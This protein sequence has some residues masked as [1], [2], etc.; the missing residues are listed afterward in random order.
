MP[1]R[2]MKP[3]PRTLRSRSGV[4]P[5]RAKVPAEAPSRPV[6]NPLPPLPV[7]IGDVLLD[8]RLEDPA[9]RARAE[10][11]YAR[12]VVERTGGFPV[13]V[14]EEAAEFTAGTAVLYRWQGA[15]VILEPT[16][17]RFVGTRR[18]Q[19]LDSLLRIL[20]SQ[21]L[22]SRS[23]LLLHAATILHEGVAFVLMGRSGAGKSTLARLSPAGS[24]LTDEISLV[25][26]GGG[27]VQ[28]HGTPFWGEFRADG[29][30]RRVR[31]GGLFE[32]V[33]AAGH[34]VEELSRRE[35]LN[36]LLA[37][38][39]FFASGGTARARL[40]ALALRFVERVPIRRLHFLPEPGFRGALT[41]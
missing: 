27:G 11:R 26:L 22:L 9:L 34:R 35:R 37:H 24:V 15:S 8:L 7:S 14:T 17:A 29:Q 12:F 21:L 39:V 25:T 38:T 19:T 2:L 6:T 13:L 16:R 20:L 33:Q 3:E 5:Y 1:P 10:E 30:N 41:L 23:G 32:L 18:E 31:V 40:L 28:A 36:S 4:A